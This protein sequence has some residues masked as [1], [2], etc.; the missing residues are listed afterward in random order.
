M[1]EFLKLLTSW[2]VC[3][4]FTLHDAIL[5]KYNIFVGLSANNGTGEILNFLAHEK[6]ATTHLLLQILK[7]Y[8]HHHKPTMCLNMCLK[9]NMH[10]D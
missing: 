3:P 2:E 6:R 7:G 8:K 10:F 1:Q 4:I 9:L 5:L